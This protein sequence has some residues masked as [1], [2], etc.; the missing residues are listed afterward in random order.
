MSFWTIHSNLPREGPGDAA[1]LTRAL[2]VAG[3]QPQWH[4]ADLG[5]GPGADLP[6]LAA[7]VGHVQGFEQHDPF[8]QAAR[9]RVADL[10]HVQVHQADMAD[11][12]RF[13]P[14]GGFDLIWSAGALYFLGGAR[15][16]D[17]IAPALRPGGM[18]TFSEACYFTEPT[19]EMRA[20]WQGYDTQTE[21]EILATVSAKG[22]SVRAAWPLP[23]EAWEAYFQ[24]IEARLARLS[25]GA[26]AEMQAAISVERTEISQWRRLKALTGYLVLVAQKA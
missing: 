7:R 9:A 5:C 15:G 6:G 1:T 11:V 20:F 26:D 23:D 16:L 18:L 8:V 10:Q 12:A 24:P 21:A 2:D 19:A 3:A 25:Q 4:A 13:A 22:F 17:Q 14:P